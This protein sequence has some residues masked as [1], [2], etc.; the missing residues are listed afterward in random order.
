[1]CAGRRV[2][3]ANHL[4]NCSMMRGGVF[5]LLRCFVPFGALLFQSTTYPRMTIIMVI[6][7]TITSV[8]SAMI[9]SCSCHNYCNFSIL[10]TSKIIARRLAGSR[11]H[12]QPVNRSRSGFGKTFCFGAFGLGFK[13]DFLLW[14]SCAGSFKASNPP[15][16]TNHHALINGLYLHS[17]EEL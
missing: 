6:V 8:F 5:L 4:F 3:T 1:M 9:R 16:K 13:V 7:A 17:Y 12:R 10:T 14:S 11:V 15:R 2:P